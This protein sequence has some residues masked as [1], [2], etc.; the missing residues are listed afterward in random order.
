MEETIKGYFNKI[1]SLLDNEDKIEIIYE[2]FGYYIFLAMEIKDEILESL[3]KRLSLSNEVYEICIA[4]KDFLNN[5]LDAIRKI[6]NEQFNDTIQ[7]N[8][9]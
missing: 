1:E 3:K 5:N 2:T 7:A 4:F 9:L 8:L 6:K